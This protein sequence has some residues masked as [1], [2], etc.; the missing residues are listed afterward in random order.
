[1]RMTPQLLT[2]PTFPQ[3]EVE[4][5]QDLLTVA[6][7]NPFAPKWIVTPNASLATHL[8][9]RLTHT[10]GF[11]VALNTQIVSLTA[12][13]RKLVQELLGQNAEDDEATLLLMLT[14]MVRQQPP[15][16]PL[17]V[18]ARIPNGARLLLP[19]I[20][21]LSES[22]LV[23]NEAVEDAVR[24]LN[25][26]PEIRQGG[27]AIRLILDVYCKFHQDRRIPLAAFALRDLAETIERISEPILH[28]ALGAELADQPPR[29]WVYGFY[30]WLDVHLQWLTAL[31]QRVSVKFFYPAP[32]GRPSARDH[33]AFAFSMPILQHLQARIPLLEHRPVPLPVSDNAET[34]AQFFA[35]TFPE[36]ELPATPPA[37]LTWQS[38][39]GPRAEAIAAAVQVRR[40]LDDPNHPVAPHDILIVAM[41]A[42]PYVPILREV[43]RDFAIPLRVAD[44]PAGPSPESEP[45]RFLIQLWREHADTEW[46]LA[47]L[48]Q[49]PNLPAARGVS[50]NDFEKKIRQLNLPGGVA[51]RRLAECIASQRANEKIR[52]T[53]AERQLICH[54]LMFVADDPAAPLTVTQMLEKLTAIA[55]TWLP[56]ACL[57]ERALRSLRACSQT[58]PT[59]AL[60]REEWAVWLEVTFPSRFHQEP[61]TEAVWFLPL[62]RARGMTARRLIWLGLA[63]GKFPPPYPE[64]P[65][66]TEPAVHALGRVLRELGHWF[67]QK[68]RLTEEMQ[69]LFW[70]INT[71]AERIHWIIPTAD[72]D[73]KALAP[74]PWVERYRQHWKNS[75]GNHAAPEI[76]RSPRLQA[77]T[78]HQ[79]D[80]AGSLLPP[81]LAPF[82]DR[83]LTSV[84]VE[85]WQHSPLHA[86]SPAGARP[87]GFPAVQ[88]A[89]W[90]STWSTDI[91]VTA[92]EDLA[93]C[94]L[95]FYVNRVMR[96]EPLEPIALARTLDRLA[97]GTL[98]HDL[99]A[100][101]GCV[102]PK[103]SPLPELARFW[104]HAT[105]SEWDR[106]WN[107]TLTAQPDIQLQLQFFPPVFQAA[108]RAEIE[109]LARRYWNW[110]ADQENSKKLVTHGFEKTFHREFPGL[111]GWKIIGK[112]DCIH[113]TEGGAWY[114]YDFKTGRRP[115]GCSNRIQLGWLIQGIVYP[116]LVNHPPVGEFRFVFLGCEPV[117]DAKSTM[118]DAEPFLHTLKG[119]LQQRVFPP[120]PRELMEN[121]TGRRDY[122]PCEYCTAISIC[123]RFEPGLIRSADQLWR[124]D[125]VASQRARAIEKLFSNEQKNQKSTKSSE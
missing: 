113:R 98:L 40:W 75:A 101:M 60:S 87:T 5:I 9:V 33:P 96:W 112:V 63:S 102:L 100:R 104:Q 48:R 20:R 11:H 117:D 47:Y 23:Y 119:F 31:A 1:M 81:G 53:D 28:R 92:L 120:F 18:L 30:E 41:Q 103:G 27:G 21:D 26:V 24:T 62:M 95:R 14:E 77:I 61:P 109:T 44:L 38:A 58:I 32:D 46:V 25:E 6:A 86:V 12:L 99:L 105:P 115:S 121:L 19:I 71:A 111:P 7:H 70:L 36:G 3:L 67:P 110:L 84:L 17:G 88:I 13:S 10:T 59:L 107:E 57:L 78:L 108:A 89:A 4:L 90:P 22:G 66:L 97:R 116:W 37:F 80:P 124:G 39:A 55:T 91:A 79:L 83:S 34:P 52:F 2:A 42:E 15:N 72:F 64:E 123:R 125:P 56:D 82:L 35:R 76:P 8:R 49:Y 68:N 29:L 85:L 106:V 54:I 114:L 93:R 16:S 122:N 43:F 45:L 50:L 73:G 94:P 65:L 51:W 74:T 69:L 118:T